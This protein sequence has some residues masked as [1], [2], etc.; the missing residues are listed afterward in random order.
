MMGMLSWSWVPVL[1]ALSVLAVTVDAGLSTELYVH[2]LCG[3]FPLIRCSSATMNQFSSLVV[4]RVRTPT[5]CAILPID[6]IA[7]VILK[8][9]GSDF[10]CI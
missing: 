2:A 8:E 4:V 5:D 6:M 1:F 10:H 7:H 9:T 3:N